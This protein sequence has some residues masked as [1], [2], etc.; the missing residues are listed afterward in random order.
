M[1]IKLVRFKNGLGHTLPV[2]ADET[3]EILHGQIKTEVVNDAQGLSV[4]R[5]EFILLQ[6]SPTN[7]FSAGV[8]EAL[9]EEG[10]L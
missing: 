4:V 7:A 5:V 6:A 8:I 1:K 10:H 9:D 3:G 2:L